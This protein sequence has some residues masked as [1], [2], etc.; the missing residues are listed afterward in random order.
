MDSPTSPNAVEIPPNAK[1]LEIWF[2]VSHSLRLRQWSNSKNPNILQKTV[3]TSV[4]WN[5]NTDL[6]DD[7]D[8][9]NSNPDIVVTMEHICPASFHT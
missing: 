3:Q 4:S 2:S 7:N 5:N 8:N 9:T 1:V 6:Y